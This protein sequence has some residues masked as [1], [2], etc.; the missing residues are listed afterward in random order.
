MR[1]VVV[2]IAAA[3]SFATLLPAQESGG[4]G[5]GQGPEVQSITQDNK[6]PD[7]TSHVVQLAGEKIEWSDELHGYLIHLRA[8]EAEPALISLDAS[9]LIV[10]TTQEQRMPPPNL[11]T[12][13]V[14]GR[15]QFTPIEFH[16]DIRITQIVGPSREGEAL[17]FYGNA[18]MCVI[19]PFNTPDNQSRTFFLAGRSGTRLD[20]SLLFARKQ[21][22]EFLG[23]YWEPISDKD[24]ILV[25]TPTAVE[26]LNV[27]VTEAREAASRLP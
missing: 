6:Y 9:K 12:R 23:R 2:A 26:V 4:S 8:K 11:A 16:T 22:L 21:K 18:A 5:S 13:M 1:P 19:P 17:E 25:I 7:G 20:L 3:L 27:K 10:D 24:A 15:D 14:K